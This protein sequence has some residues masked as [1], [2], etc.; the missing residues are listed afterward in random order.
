MDTITI[1]ARSLDVRP[2]LIP[3]RFRLI[4]PDLDGGDSFAATSLLAAVV[5]ACCPAVGELDPAARRS[6]IRSDVIDYG[7]QCMHELVDGGASVRQVCD[8]GQTLIVWLGEIT[9]SEPEVA[10]ALGNSPGPEA[11]ST[12]TTSGSD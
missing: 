11:G 12:S 7:D 1:G 2:P 4:A 5:G 6:A 8:A 9:P 3:I 10:E